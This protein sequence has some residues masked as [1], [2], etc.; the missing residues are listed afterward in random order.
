[1]GSWLPTA[2]Q[3]TAVAHSL[4]SGE[5]EP[6][7]G[8][9]RT[10]MREVAVPDEQLGSEQG[11]YSSSKEP[12]RSAEAGLLPG[13]IRPLTAPRPRPRPH[14]NAEAQGLQDG[15][16]RTWLIN[17]VSD[18]HLETSLNSSCMEM[19]GQQGAEPGYVTLASRTCCCEHLDGRKALRAVSAE[20]ATAVV[21]S[22]PQ[23][24]GVYLGVAF[25]VSEPE[26]TPVDAD[27]GFRFAQG[28]KSASVTWN[29]IPELCTQTKVNRVYAVCLFV[30]T[31]PGSKKMLCSGN[32]LTVH[33]A[34]SGTLGKPDLQ[35]WR[36]G[37]GFQPFYP[38]NLDLICWLKREEKGFLSLLW[39]PNWGASVVPAAA[40]P[41]LCGCLPRVHRACFFAELEK[42]LS[43][44]PK[45]VCI[46]KVVGTRN[47]WKNIVVLCVNS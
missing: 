25:P 34:P 37:L 31:L 8:Q 4:V 15:V 7:P 28:L 45:K 3:A 32:V 36:R 10:E 30:C 21:S 27:Y 39:C 18:G 42:E 24:F 1:M 26:V 40:A 16:G 29:I 33:L 47:L 43:R 6:V 41:V 23:S 11:L 19:N 44:R 13:L 46:V 38:G 35:S 22:A 12:A 2:P 14:E 17:S 9:T 5:V 20:V